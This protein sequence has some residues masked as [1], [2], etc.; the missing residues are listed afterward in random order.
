MYVWKRPFN[1]KEHAEALF[2]IGEW[3][4]ANGIDTA[5]RYR[6]GRDL[7]LRKRPRLARGEV[8]EP[9]TGEEPKSTVCRIASALKDSVF[10]IQGPPGAGKTFTGARMIC[11]LADCR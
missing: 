8:L 10:A 11:E 3:V 2:R 7:L 9:H 5:G 1:V 6:A 4:A